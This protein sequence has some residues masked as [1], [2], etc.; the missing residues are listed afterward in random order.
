MP[1]DD[2]FAALEPFRFPATGRPAYYVYQVGDGGPP[3]ILLHEMDG[4]GHA[5]QRLALQLSQRFTVYTPTLYG[6]L[7]PAGNPNSPRRMVHW[8][9]G[10]TRLCIRREMYCFADAKRSPFTDWV[11]ALADHL[12]DRHGG[13]VGV[14][15]MCL[16]GGIVLAALAHPS[17]G[18]GVS[19]QPALPWVK[20]VGTTA[21][22]KASIGLSE[23]ELAAVRD[24]ETPLRVFRFRNDAACPD[25]RIAT[26]EA[27]FAS[28]AV[29]DLI[30]PVGKEDALH[31]T[32]TAAFRPKLAA[33]PAVEELSR[34]AIE[35]ASD[36]L[37]GA[38]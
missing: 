21:Q 20:K 38:L 3:V 13:R 30:E 16:T 28:A 11:Q 14:V 10:I 22:R 2:P 25:E 15:G 32:L 31:P 4:L 8:A 36:F 17:I 26:I 34:R 12:S 7:A 6:R 37:L 19:A 33:D 23:S 27:C 5:C 24:T 9:S 29:D 1:P 18:A 35:D